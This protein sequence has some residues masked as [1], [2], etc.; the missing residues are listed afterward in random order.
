MR[1]N[2]IG[3]A[4][5][6]SQLLRRQN[7]DHE[8]PHM[9]NMAG[10]GLGECSDSLFGENCFGEAPVCRIGFAAD[11]SPLLQACD[12]RDNRDSDALVTS[13]SELI[14][15]VRCALSESMAMT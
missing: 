5:E 8:R 11:Q 14:R 3:V 12:H 15:I 4:P 9:S 13:A 1:H 10:S 6:P 7:I 2:A